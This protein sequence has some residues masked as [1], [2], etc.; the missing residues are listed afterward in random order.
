MSEKNLNADQPIDDV[1]A[2]LMTTIQ[3][4]GRGF[5][6][7][8]AR[9]GD[10]V[11]I[12]VKESLKPHDEWRPPADYRAHK[13]ETTSSFIA[14]AT[15][16]G[17]EDKSLVFV[18]DTGAALVIDEQPEEGSREV[19]TMDLPQADDWKEWSATLGKPLLHKQLLEFLLVHEANLS[20]PGVLAA[21]T[22]VKVNS[23]VNYESDIKDDGKTVGLVFKTT[24][25][26]EELK[27]FPKTFPISVPALQ[28][29]EGGDRWQPA[30]IRLEVNLPNEP[31]GKPTFTL[32]CSNWRHLLKQRIEREV[33][34]IATALKGWTVVHGNFN[35][36]DHELKRA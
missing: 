27:K 33:D 22:S 12:E 13:I 10:K 7:A 21:I 25:A 23:T 36:R 3:R 30:T 9:E 11:T 32:Y 24:Q 34:A 1:V 15:R 31:Q 17:D 35:T 4:K 2:G 6:L 29:D 5:A 26:G 8:T 16:Y 20:D 28:S 14:Y 19:V 18:S